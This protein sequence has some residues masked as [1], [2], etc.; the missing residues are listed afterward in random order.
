MYHVLKIVMFFGSPPFSIAVVW[1]SDSSH[2]QVV[3]ERGIS[4]FY[5]QTAHVTALAAVFV[6]ILPPWPF[7]CHTLSFPGTS[8]CQCHH[9]DCLHILVCMKE[10]CKKVVSADLQIP[11]YCDWNISIVVIF[12]EPSNPIREGSLSPEEESVWDGTHKA[13]R[14]SLCLLLVKPC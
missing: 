8:D 1:S 10:C 6:Q 5:N 2:S 11:S 7:Y 13:K 4:R 12:G 3:P 14:C 9:H